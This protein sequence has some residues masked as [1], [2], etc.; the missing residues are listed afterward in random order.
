MLR[1]CG[2]DLSLDP[3]PG[4]SEIAR[5]LEPVAKQVVQFA[6][7]QR[8]HQSAVAHDVEL[9]FSYATVA[10]ETWSCDS[11]NVTTIYDADSDSDLT[12]IYDF[13]NL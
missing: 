9:K 13:I 7:M 2:T 12:K 10:R 6:Q 3:Q 11:A 1:I 4:S 5:A 8:H